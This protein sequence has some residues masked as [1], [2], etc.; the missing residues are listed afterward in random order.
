MEKVLPRFCKALSAASELV[1]DEVLS[2]EVSSFVRATA[3]SK[4][5]GASYRSLCEFAESLLERFVSPLTKHLARQVFLGQDPE[6]NVALVLFIAE[7][8]AN[9]IAVLSQQGMRI[10]YEIPSYCVFAR[11]MLPAV[12][13]PFLKMSKDAQASPIP[14]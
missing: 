11:C 1:E 4:Y 13:P 2:A 7:T 9:G 14:L 3:V 5:T 6:K 8:T 12:V 10:D